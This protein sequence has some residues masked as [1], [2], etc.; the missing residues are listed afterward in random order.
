MSSNCAGPDGAKALSEV[1]GNDRQNGYSCRLEHLSVN[2]N[3]IGNCGAQSFAAALASAPAHLVALQLEENRIGS[4]AVQTLADASWQ[5]P[6]LQ[7]INCL[8]NFVTDDW[9]PL[10]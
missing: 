8:R 1:I 10:L 4:A 7:W 2:K 3:G 6:M 9:M 5:A